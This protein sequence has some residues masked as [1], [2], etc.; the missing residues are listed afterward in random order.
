LG[1]III[2]PTSIVLGDYGGILFGLLWV[3]LGYMLWSRRVASAEQ[4]SRVR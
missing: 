1:L 2:P 3:A 4:P